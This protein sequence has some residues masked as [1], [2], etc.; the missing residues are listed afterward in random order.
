MRTLVP[1]EFN[2]LRTII[3]IAASASAFV[4]VQ[5]SEVGAKVLRS[6]HGASMIMIFKGADELRRFER[7]AKKPGGA[8]TPESLL[9]CK[10]PQGTGIETLGSGY[11]TAFVKVIDGPSSGCQ[12]TVPKD[13]VQEQ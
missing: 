11:R 9:A 5:T 2:L 8:D 10:V 3:A 6:K 4:V 13:R 1:H 7:I 12:G